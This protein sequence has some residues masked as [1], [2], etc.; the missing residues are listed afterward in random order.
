MLHFSLLSITDQAS[1]SG[2][3]M[4]ISILFQNMRICGTRL[5]FVDRLSSNDTSKI[6]SYRND[7]NRKA[8]SSHLLDYRSK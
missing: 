8:K 2:T 4:K 6:I 5:L 7:D 1:S 3:P